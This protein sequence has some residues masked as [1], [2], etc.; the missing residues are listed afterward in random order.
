ME[1]PCLNNLLTIPPTSQ[2]L[3]I[4]SARKLLINDSNIMDEIIWKGV[5]DIESRI[6]VCIQNYALE[7][8]FNNIY[9]CA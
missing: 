8:H 1:W 3:N 5:E 2:G 7:L 6:G 4:V 9:S